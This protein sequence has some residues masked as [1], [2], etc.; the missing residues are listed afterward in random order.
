MQFP[1]RLLDNDIIVHLR[2]NAPGD[3][4]SVMDV[5]VINP[6]KLQKFFQIFRVILHQ[7]DCA[8]K[9]PPAGQNGVI[10]QFLFL[11]QLQVNP[12]PFNGYFTAMGN[13]S[14]G[15][16]SAVCNVLSHLQPTLGWSRRPP[17]S[18]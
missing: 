13:Y 11:R 16:H 1:R 7:V 17:R 12:A 8:T 2:Q 14:A 5:G 18:A 15:P 3:W 10:D 4:N 6:I 9:Q